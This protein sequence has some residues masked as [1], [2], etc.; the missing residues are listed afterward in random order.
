MASHRDHF[1]L[2]RKRLEC[3]SDANEHE[4]SKLHTRIVPPARL[5]DA[6]LVN[7]EPLWRNLTFHHF[8]LILSATFGA[9]AVAIAFFL[10]LR[11]ATHYLKPY[12][13]KQCVPLGSVYTASNALT[14]TALYVSCL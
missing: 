12:E 8:G 4:R 6:V 5:A 7:E 10:I 13:Q 11:H 3:E 14:T 2:L 1:G 9:L